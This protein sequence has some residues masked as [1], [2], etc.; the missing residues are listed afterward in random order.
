MICIVAI[1]TRVK[2]SRALHSTRLECNCVE[3]LATNFSM[4][5]TT[6]SW[7]FLDTI[8]TSNKNN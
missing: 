6:N 8:T 3:A 2:G 1:D 5:L 7:S 4:I